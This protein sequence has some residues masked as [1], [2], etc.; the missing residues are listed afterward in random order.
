MPNQNPTLVF[1]AGIGNSG[2]EH[3]QRQWFERETD[4]AVWVEHSSWDEPVAATW[5]KELDEALAA[6]QGPK[7][8]VAH[9]LGCTLLAQWASAKAENPA[10]AD[11][12]AAFLVAAPDVTGENF[13][14][15]AEGFATDAYALPLPFPAVVVASEDDPY[16]SLE[17]AETAAGQLGARL[18]NVGSLGH[19]NASSGLG[20]WS[21]GWQLFQDALKA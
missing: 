8:V 17:H 14:T 11:V 18:H 5:V 1:L 10:L 6:V 9:S 3:W 12:T 16:G 4:R 2:P 7:V 13:P 20:D 21:E 15:Q 19:I